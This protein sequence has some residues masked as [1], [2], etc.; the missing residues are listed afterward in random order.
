MGKKKAKKQ[1]STNV[2]NEKILR[3]I[4]LDIGAELDE[5]L[6][7]ILEDWATSLFEKKKPKR[8]KK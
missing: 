8:K 4:F 1:S 2:L 3:E 6:D 7:K 5:M